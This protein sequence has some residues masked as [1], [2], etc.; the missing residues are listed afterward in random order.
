MRW[1]NPLTVGSHFVRSQHYAGS[2]SSFAI[3][4]GSTSTTNTYQVVNSVI[5]T[6]TTT[7]AILFIPAYLTMSHTAASPLIYF[8][9]RVFQDETNS[10][11]L[12]TNSIG[13]VDL[14]PVIG[15]FRLVSAT[16]TFQLGTINAQPGRHLVY[17]MVSNQ[18]AGTLS[19]GEPNSNDEWALFIQGTVVTS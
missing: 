9:T 14:S 6:T 13:N 19:W 5:L 8:S 7:K 10:T 15:N 17:L 11:I 16:F 4:S 3:A 2:S 12:S 1:R 18:T